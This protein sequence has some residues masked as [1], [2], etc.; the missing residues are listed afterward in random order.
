MKKDKRQQSN[1]DDVVITLERPPID[2]AQLVEACGRLQKMI[3]KE[4]EAREKRM[5]KL[6][7]VRQEILGATDKLLT[8]IENIKHQEH[9]FAVVR[10][11]LS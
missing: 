10:Y 4:N 3:E 9:K 8:T 6:E 11:Y 7:T 5:Q 2:A 1:V